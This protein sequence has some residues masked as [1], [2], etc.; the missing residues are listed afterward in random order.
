[1]STA[2]DGM[3]RFAL[4]A[5]E[6]ATEGP[7]SRLQRSQSY[8]TATGR[9]FHLRTRQRDEQKGGWNRYWFEI[10]DEC[11]QAGDFFVL[12]CDLDF[13][14]VVPVAQW[15]PHMDRFSISK[16]GTSTQ[17]RQPHIYWRDGVYELRE[18]VRDNA[19]VLDVRPWLN[20]FELRA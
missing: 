7:V 10:R 5:I 9:S 12:V 8:R 2:V 6:A 18:A 13:V 14:V 19:L 16:P 1:M 15:L 3:R 20:R 17:A 4:D 11:W